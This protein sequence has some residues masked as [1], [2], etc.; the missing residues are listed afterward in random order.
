MVS[1][2]L[3]G[4][5][6]ALARSRYNDSRTRAGAEIAKHATL[7]HAQQASI[8]CHEIREAPCDSDLFTHPVAMD[9]DG[10]HRAARWVT[11]SGRV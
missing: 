4:S 11:A 2:S 7:R 3:S 9:F 10:H 5:V 8:D 1:P 6:S